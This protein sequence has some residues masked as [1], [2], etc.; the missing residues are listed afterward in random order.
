MLVKGGNAGA[1]KGVD[2][3]FML[4]HMH[5]NFEA[6]VEAN[7]SCN[8]LVAEQAVIIKDGQGEAKAQAVRLLGTKGMKKWSRRS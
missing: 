2:I 1:G 8:E 6:M 7:L 3:N 5:C 4:L